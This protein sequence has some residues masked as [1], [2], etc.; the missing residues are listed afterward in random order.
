MK[1]DLSDLTIFI[2]VMPIGLWGAYTGDLL[3]G[4]WVNDGRVTALQ[5]LCDAGRVALIVLQLSLGKEAI[6]L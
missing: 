2:F 5:V 3:R 1:S 4:F 6:Q